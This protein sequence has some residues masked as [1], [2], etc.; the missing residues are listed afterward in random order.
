MLQNIR[1]N[2]QGWIAKTI[3]G[4]I[5]LLLA[6]TGFDAIFNAASNRKNAAEVNGEKISQNEVSQAAELQV[7][8]LRQKLGNDF[9]ASLLNEKML[10]DSALKGLID[11]QLLLQGAKKSGFAFSESS[12]DQL[13]LQTPDFQIAGKFSPE[14]FDQVIRQ[15]N[16]SRLQFRQ[17][18]ASEMLIGQLRAGIAG[19]DFVTDAEVQAFA[20][21]EKQTRDFAT[22]TLKADTKSVK[23]ADEEVK[24]YYEGHPDQ[25]MSPEQVVVE[26]VELKKDAF[27]DQVKV[28]DSD[29]QDLYRKETANLSEQRHAAHILLEVD[30]KV[31]DE[32]TKAKLEG[33]R[34]RIEQGEDFAALA[35]EFSVDPGSAPQGGDLGFAGPGTY[36]P[37]F[38]K[39][40]YALKQGEVSEPVKTQYGWHLIK[41]LGVQAPEIPSFESSKENLVREL[42]TQQVEQL[43]VE[44]T[45]KLEDASFEASDLAQPAQELGL[46]VQTSKPFGREGGEGLAASRQVLQAAFSPEVLDDGANSGAL[47]LDPD[48]V[49]VLRA[50]EHLKPQRQP[51]EQVSSGIRDQLTKERAT[52]AA[53]TIGEQLLAQLKKG[54]K[55][56]LK[57][58]KVVE[59]ATRSQEGIDPAILQALFRAAKP[60]S[61]D[62]PVYAGVELSSGDY[63]VLRLDGVSEPQDALSEEDKTSY[64]RFL[65]SRS[66]QEAYGAYRRQ[67]EEKAE[68]ER[69]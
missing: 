3:I 16:Y 17:M 35:K 63:V 34:K 12:L 10:H 23:I 8:Q 46:K 65:A 7:R 45:K 60:E 18:L 39:T 43:F 19:S 27:F 50:K 51:L 6:L 25:F 69:Y 53:K 47:E 38:E 24:A 5:M 62:K 64:K 61:K 4:V 15:M 1:D 20:R 30:P 67:L 28:S 44:A 66:G 56:A 40:L 33:L 58:W 22:L 55:P 54:E 2:S 68:I 13:I 29:L 21:L 52:A 37:A 41:L 9:D 48:T 11:R 14:R 26:Y 32:Q 59:A 42:K 31:G 36:D 49:I 57:D